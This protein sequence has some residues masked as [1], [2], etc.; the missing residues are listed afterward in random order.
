MPVSAMFTARLIKATSSTRSKF[1]GSVPGSPMQTATACRFGFGVFTHDIE[2]P[3]SEALVEIAAG[4]DMAEARQRLHDDFDD[5]GLAGI[6]G[7]IADQ[8]G[9][10]I[11]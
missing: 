10:A 6:R 11:D 3:E 9:E 8:G 5:L 7:D 1:C 4:F 2:S